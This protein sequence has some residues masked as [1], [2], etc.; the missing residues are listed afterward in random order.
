MNRPDDPF[1]AKRGR[2]DAPHVRDLNDLARRLRRAASGPRFVP[3][4]DPDSAGTQSRTLVLMESP[5]PRTVRAGDLGFSS[6]DN[7]DPTAQALRAARSA[8]GLGRGDYL[9]WN[10][11]PWA[12]GDDAGRTRAPRRRDLDEARPALVELISLL[13]NLRTVVAVGSSALTG[14]M[15]C[16][17]LEDD[18]PPRVPVVLGVPHPSPRNATQHQEARERLRNALSTAARLAAPH[19]RR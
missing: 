5:G 4:F 18:L 1:V 15:Q 10:V 13:P 6:E 19:D 8:A 16:L 14:V 17:T 3:W 11:V 2:V 12:L 7:G 9:R